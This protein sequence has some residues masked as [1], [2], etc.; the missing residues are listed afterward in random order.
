MDEAAIVAA[1]RA[2]PGLMA[3]LAQAV[4]APAPRQPQSAHTA[5][6]AQLLGV[7]PTPRTLERMRS[8]AV[9][10]TG[11]LMLHLEVQATHPDGL[12]TTTPKVL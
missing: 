9:A 5:S 11:T 1:L 12:R 7:P 10:R 2:N 8:V 3:C 4:A 6:P